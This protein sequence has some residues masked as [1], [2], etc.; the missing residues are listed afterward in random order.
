MCGIAGLLY[1]DRNREVDPALLDRATDSVAHRGPDGRGTHLDRNLGLGHRRLAIIDTTD[2]AA[3]PFCNEDGTVWIVFNGEIYNF[4]EFTAGLEAKGHTFKSRSD[5]E[6]IVH[7]YEEHGARVVEHL[8]GMFA[9]AIWD[10]RKRTLLLA[11]D[12]VGEKPLYYRL[13]RDSLH[14]GS[15]IKAIL[16]DRSVARTPDPVALD[17]YLTY[18]YVPGPLTAF[19]G[20]SKLPPGHTLLVHEDGRSELSA[21]WKLS[22]GPKRAV[23]GEK[24]ERAVEEEIRTVLDE[25]TQLRMI[26]DVPLGAFLSGGVDSSAVVA[27][28][29]RVAGSNN[30]RTF[31][32]GFDE[33]DYDESDYAA[34][35]ARHLSTTH[36]ALTLR[37]PADTRALLEKISWHYGEPFADS[38]CVPTF[39]V[40]ELARARVTVALSGDGGDELFLGYGRYKATAFEQELESHPLLAALGTSRAGLWALQ[41]LGK[42]ELGNMLGHARTNLLPGALRYLPKIEHFSPEKKREICTESFLR[43][44]AHAGDARELVLQK[45]KASD[46]ETLVE[47]V[48]HADFETYLPDDILV[49]VDVAAMACALETRPPLLDHV[50]AQLVAALP[51]RLKMAGTT[52]KA[53]LKSALAPRL[54]Q[55]ILHRR[56][57]GFGVP[58]EHWFRGS[59]APL[60]EEILLSRRCLDRGVLEEKGVRR[61]LEEHK[62]GTDWQYPLFNLLML[63][64]WFRTWIDGAGERPAAKAELAPASKSAGS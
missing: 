14:F 21:Y 34:T 10:S 39:A 50:L 6:V 62:R 23:E 45:I 61:M 40:S 59:L 16:E 47:K 27:S 30:V 48:A 12:R 51:S 13:T 11:R 3:Q 22:Y 8:R 33:K 52:T 5:T 58:L 44:V 18:G 1:F 20:I 43:S 42:R 17:R 53:I 28:M 46:G 2:A 64:L 32:I 38:S 35:V 9:L 7:L 41:K 37:P 24:A 49:K 60:L 19:K 15:E 63:E 26:S 25:A 29:R 31:S 57:M 36:E 4:Q 54:P 56:K 55:E